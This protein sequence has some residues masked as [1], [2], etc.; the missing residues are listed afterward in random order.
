MFDAAVERLQ[1]GRCNHKN[2]VR[3]CGDKGSSWRS[4]WTRDS[5][6]L[7]GNLEGLAQQL[8]SD[9]LLSRMV[10]LNDLGELRALTTFDHPQNHEDPKRDSPLDFVPIVRLNFLL[11][12]I[13]WCKF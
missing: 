7:V 12:H 13:L 9:S 6:L 4:L 10:K 8:I 11:K 1:M 5:W 3:R 2:A